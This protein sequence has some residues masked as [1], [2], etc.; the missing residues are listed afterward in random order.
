MNGTVTC[1]NLTPY[2]LQPVPEVGKEYHA[3]DDGKISP[4]RL[5]T[6]KIVEITP[7]EEADEELLKLWRQEVAECYWLYASETDYLVRAKWDQDTDPM[8]FVRTED[9]GWFSLGFWGSRLDI[10]GS[11]YKRM[12]ERCG[13]E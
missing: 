12:I 13:K 2:K 1:I 7:F 4:S 11:L 8:Y 3:F 10:D 5:E 9:G 6:V